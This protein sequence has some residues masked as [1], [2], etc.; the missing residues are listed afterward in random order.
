M[1][2]EINPSELLFFI[3]KKLA[4]REPVYSQADHIIDAATIDKNSL[5]LLLHKKDY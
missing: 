3:Q 1:I 5:S 4:E 2:K